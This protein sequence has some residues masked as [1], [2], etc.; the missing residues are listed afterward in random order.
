VFIFT[1]ACFSKKCFSIIVLICFYCIVVKFFCE[2][3]GMWSVGSGW[4][5]GSVFSASPLTLPMSICK[6]FCGFL[7]FCSVGGSGANLIILFCYLW[8]TV[9]CKS[10]YVWF[11][12]TSL[13]SCILLVPNGK[14]RARITLSFKWLATGCSSGVCVE[15]NKTVTNT[16]IYFQCK[17]PIC[18]QKLMKYQN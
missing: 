1:C 9:H 10:L 7:W 17:T 15:T 5:C 8:V 4:L 6:L 11:P 18:F 16:G 14:S 13:F 2:G 12:C 3:A